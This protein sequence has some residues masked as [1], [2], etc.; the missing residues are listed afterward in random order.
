MARV[1][2]IKRGK[3][4]MEVISEV[5]SGWLPPVAAILA[6]FGWTYKLNRD[7]RS[8]LLVEI[9]KNR[10]E[11]SDHFQAHIHDAGSGEVLFRA[12]ASR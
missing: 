11:I 6:I 12:L 3:A 9:A 4:N 1:A 2:A 7:L 8:D 10:Q 5:I